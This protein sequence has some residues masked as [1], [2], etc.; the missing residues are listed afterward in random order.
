[1]KELTRLSS[2]VAIIALHMFIFS[3]L[4]EKSINIRE[5]SGNTF[6]ET[7]SVNYFLFG[8]VS[9]DNS[10]KEN[11]ICKG[12]SIVSIRSVFSRQRYICLFT[13]G[14]YCRDNLEIVCHP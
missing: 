1:M 13:I 3:C 14:M 12:G 11:V 7:Y 4:S 2:R 8:Q 10:I 5:N 9:F 6:K